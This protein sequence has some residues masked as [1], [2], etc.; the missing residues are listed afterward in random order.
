MAKKEY[1]TQEAQT[2]ADKNLEYYTSDWKSDA[3]TREAKQE[4]AKI[5][6]AIGKGERTEI[7]EGARRGAQKTLTNRENARIKAENERRQ[8]AYDAAVKREQERYQREVDA[9]NRAV[10]NEEARYQR[11]MDNYNAQ[12]RAQRAAAA[13]QRQAQIRA[14][15]SRKKSRSPIRKLGRKI[16]KIFGW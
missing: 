1:L 10:A 9:Y 14:K 6:R 5:Q 15:S 11:A 8:A 7:V 4:Q 3:A 16:G 12:V 13:R 2:Q